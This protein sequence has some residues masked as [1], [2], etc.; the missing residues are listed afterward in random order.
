MLS[1]V[2][3]RQGQYIYIYV[4][5]ERSSFA[6]REIER[7][8]VRA[9][10][11]VLR[12]VDNVVARTFDRRTWQTPRSLPPLSAAEAATLLHGRACLLLPAAVS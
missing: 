2:P 11:R 10:V 7:A 3:R 9:C 12:T 6:Y 4:G 8:C 5:V 1:P